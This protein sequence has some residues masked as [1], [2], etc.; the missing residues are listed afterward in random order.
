MESSKPV[1]MMCWY[2][3]DECACEHCDS[4]EKPKQMTEWWEY[5]GHWVDTHPFVPRCLVERLEMQRHGGRCR[6]T[7]CPGRRCPFSQS[8]NLGW[9]WT[10]ENPG[11][12]LFLSGTTSRQRKN[13]A[14]CQ[15][16]NINFCTQQAFSKCGKMWWERNSNWKWKLLFEVKLVLLLIDFWNER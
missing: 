12:L 11:F 10:D 9:W 1:V 5:E 13:K 2:E 4:L 6:K 15:T 16:T 14:T 3:L 8:S 7:P